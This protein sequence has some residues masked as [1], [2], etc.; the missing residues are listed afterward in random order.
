MSGL[1]CGQKFLE[2][3]DK[4]RNGFTGWYKVRQVSRLNRTL[5]VAGWVLHCGLM[6]TTAHLK[7]TLWIND[8][9]SRL[10]AR[11]P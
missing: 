1:W 3:L 11:V 8:D 4:W 9:A 5:I 2:W 7:I 10:L 6:M